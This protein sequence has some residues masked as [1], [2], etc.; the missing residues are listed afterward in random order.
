MFEP[1]YS[2]LNQYVWQTNQPITPEEDVVP[3]IADS[4]GDSYVHVEGNSGPMPS[5]VPSLVESGTQNL[6]PFYQKC[7]ISIELAEFM[8]LVPE[9]CT[10]SLADA[11]RA[12]QQYLKNNAR[13]WS[14]RLFVP[15]IPIM[16]LLGISHVTTEVRWADVPK[17]LATRHFRIYSMVVTTLPTTIH[18]TFIPRHLFTENLRVRALTENAFPFVSDDYPNGIE[19][20]KR[21]VFG[22]T[23][24]FQA[25]SHFQFPE[26]ILVDQVYTYWMTT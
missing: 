25:D 10:V 16:N 5:V 3:I 14:K 15:D 20:G 22:Y 17:F 21:G 18:F 2:F 1:F 11:I 24:E 26:N 9:N 12:I 8:G 13:P 4:T 7:P 19:A 23:S 6:P